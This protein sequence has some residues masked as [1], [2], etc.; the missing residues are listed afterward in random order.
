MS[1]SLLHEHLDTYYIGGKMANVVSPPIAC[2]ADWRPE[3]AY[4]GELRDEF[5]LA[6]RAP[7]PTLKI[8]GAWEKW[9]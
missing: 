8:E 9:D 1:P 5:Y 7:F 2:V 6:L 4:I 3:Q